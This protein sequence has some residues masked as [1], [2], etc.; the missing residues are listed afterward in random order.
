MDGPPQ[1]LDG[2]RSAGSSPVLFQTEIIMLYL[3]TPEHPH[4]GL[5]QRVALD[6]FVAQEGGHPG[7]VPIQKPSHFLKRLWLLFEPL[8]DLIGTLSRWSASSSIQRFSLRDT[9]K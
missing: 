7:E 3:Q 9:P 4:P 5:G 2:L 1:I 8:D 6:P